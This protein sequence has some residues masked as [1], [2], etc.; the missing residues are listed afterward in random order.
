MRL[1]RKVR[2]DR[3]CMNRRHNGQQVLLLGRKRQRRGSVA[4]E[5]EA[6]EKLAGCLPINSTSGE[7]GGEEGEG[8]VNAG[9]ELERNVHR[10]DLQERAES[11]CVTERGSEEATDATSRIM[12]RVLFMPFTVITILSLIPYISYSIVDFARDVRGRVTSRS[13]G[14]R[15]CCVSQSACM[16]ALLAALRRYFWAALRDVFRFRK[17][18]AFT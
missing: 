1:I 15:C 11:L 14:R 9:E 4:I 16:R 7:E 13:M 3:D 12:A 2:T 8:D 18:D 10:R 6:E 5:E 17:L